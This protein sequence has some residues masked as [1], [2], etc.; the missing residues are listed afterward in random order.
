MDELLKQMLEM[1]LANVENV[2]LLKAKRLYS[3]LEIKNH[4]K[5]QKSPDI[6]AS[7]LRLYRRN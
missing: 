3:E 4:T 2:G 5:E 7:W 1:G 6:W